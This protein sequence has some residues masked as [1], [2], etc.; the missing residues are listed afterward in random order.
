MFSMRILRRVLLLLLFV[1]LFFATWQFTHHNDQ[2]VQ[3]D[4]IFWTAQHTPLWAA[5]LISFSAGILVA[6]ALLLLPMA[7]T[8]LLARR[9]RREVRDLESE[10]HQL[11]NLPLAGS[12][13]P[14]KGAPAAEVGDPIPATPRGR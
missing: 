9:Y 3:V 7:R 5:L 13:G 14:G 8:G 1:G 2:G 6:V 4:L 10:I 12:D 11:R